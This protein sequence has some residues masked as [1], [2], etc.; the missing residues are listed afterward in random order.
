LPSPSFRRV[1]K[2]W[3]GSLNYFSRDL[4]KVSKCHISRISNLLVL[5]GDF[6]IPIFKLSCFKLVVFQKIIINYKK[7]WKNECAYKIQP[8]DGKL[9]AWSIRLLFLLMLNK[10]MNIWY[11]FTHEVQGSHNYIHKNHNVDSKAWF[12]LGIK[13]IKK[14]L[15]P[16][17][18]IFCLL[19][20]PNLP[21][22]ATTLMLEY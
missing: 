3:P 2:I 19:F 8:Q 13:A 14:N 22:N 10:F 21:I 5:K 16:T 6:H 20:D 12:R 4:G 1:Y 15:G 17:L 18:S 7:M 11:T 9:K